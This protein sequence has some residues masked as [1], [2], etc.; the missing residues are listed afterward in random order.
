MASDWHKDTQ[1]K[2]IQ[3]YKEEGYK[4][5][6]EKK[7][8]FEIKPTRKTQF[9]QVDIIAKKNNEIILIEI[10]DRKYHT[11]EYEICDYGAGYVELGGYFVFILSFC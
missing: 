7:I 5:K 11:T 10:E 2:M 8:G 4:V 9:K 1:E 6:K 3:E